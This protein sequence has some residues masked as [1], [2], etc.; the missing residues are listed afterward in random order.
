MKR[1]YVSLYLRDGEFDIRFELEITN[2]DILTTWEKLA[3][4]MKKYCPMGAD[5]TSA[6][7]YEVEDKK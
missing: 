5:V 6:T 3:D 7:F 2:Y 4:I 1:K